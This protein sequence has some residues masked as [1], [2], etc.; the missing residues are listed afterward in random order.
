MSTVTLTTAALFIGCSLMAGCG[1]TPT[2]QPKGP[3]PKPQ[4]RPAEVSEATVCDGDE[5]T[6]YRVSAGKPLPEPVPGP[7]VDVTLEGIDDGNQDVLKLVTS[8]AG[9]PLAPAKIRADIEKL[10][11]TGRFEDVSVEARTSPKGLTLVFVVVPRPTTGKLFF[12]GIAQL[13]KHQVDDAVQLHPGKPF[14]P[15][16]LTFT[17]TRLRDAYAGAGYWFAKVETRQL[18]T[19]ALHLCLK[20]DEGPKVTIAAWTFEGVKLLSEEQLR[21]QMDSRDGTVN[22]SG[23][24]YRPDVWGADAARIQA[25]YYDKGFVLSQVASPDVSVAKD[26]RTVT[27]TIR[28]QEGVQFRVGKVTFSGDALV[29]GQRYDSAVQIKSGE[30][31]S[32]TKV[33]EDLGRIREFHEQTGSWTPQF[34]VTPVTQ[35]DTDKSV[36]HIDFQLR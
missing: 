16:Q 4:A 17:Q 19:E 22:N 28:I 10:W 6:P 2:P 21:A 32:R 30:V 14:E 23:G 25:L 18:R 11:A 3:P 15:Q 9:A 26:R 27:V 24:I 35:V 8:R 7:V 31:F 33:M 34:E 5:L 20:V 36:V 13:P 1:G 12:Q 29:A